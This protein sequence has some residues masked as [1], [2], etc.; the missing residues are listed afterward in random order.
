MWGSLKNK[1]EREIL[2]EKME[3]VG[4]GGFSDS[5]YFAVFVKRTKKVD[6][7][8]IKYG[9]R[10]IYEKNW[11]EEWYDVYNW[12]I[13]LFAREKPKGDYEQ[14]EEEEFKTYEEALTI[15][16][17]FEKEYPKKYHFETKEEKEK[18][19]QIE[20]P[21][22]AKSIVSQALMELNKTNIKEIKSKLSG[23]ALCTNPKL[24]R[25]AYELLDTKQKILR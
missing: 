1:K 21:D 16:E 15:I 12:N 25:K 5:D 13:I 3:V 9:V 18:E 22:W 23:T 11:D 10:T 8:L 20:F 7:F 17:I 19:E 6:F 14:I 24:L 2:A 4:S